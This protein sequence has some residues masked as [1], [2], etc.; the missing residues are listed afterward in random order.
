MRGSVKKPCLTA[1]IAG[2]CMAFLLS[3]S[4]L[5]A[6][7]AATPS[8]TK[9]PSVK[10][11]PSPVP[12][13]DPLAKAEAELKQAPGVAEARSLE[14]Q[15][16][17]LRQSHLQAMVRLLGAQAESALS[18]HDF[19]AAEQAASDAIVLQ[20]DQPILRRERAR[21]RAAAGDFQDAIADLGVAVQGD[22]GDVV[23]WQM[24]ADIE[25]QRHDYRAAVAALDQALTLDPHL[26]GGEALRRKLVLLRDGQPA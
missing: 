23:A 7:P 11:S 5:A 4:L 26:Q 12:K 18:H 2:V 10:S 13:P 22:A 6:P 16:E 25:A 3:G 1:R 14:A 9:P 8:A 21:I 17:N 15:A 24:L 20:P 19:R